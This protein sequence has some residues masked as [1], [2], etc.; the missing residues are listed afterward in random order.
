MATITIREGQCLLDICMQYNGTIDQLLDTAKL[1]GLSMTGLLTV[2]GWLQTTDVVN[3]ARA[4]QFLQQKKAIPASVTE[5][6]LP[7][8][9]DFMQIG[10]DFKVN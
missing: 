3:D 10:S 6:A 4:V 5:N 2:G 1:N 8:G 7:G 9:I